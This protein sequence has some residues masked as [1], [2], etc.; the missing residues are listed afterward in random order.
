MDKTVTISSSGQKIP[1]G[2]ILC[3][4]QNYLKHIDEMGSSK[5]QT[6]VI[7]IK[8]ATALV[9]KGGSIQLP[10]FTEN[11]HH[12]VE[13]VVVIGKEGKDIGRE[14]T[15]EFI[16]GYALGLD[17]TLR[18]MQSA[19]KKKGLPWALAKGFDT[20]APISSVILKEE[21]PDPHNLDLQL[22]V[23]GQLRQKGNTKD[24][25]FK[26]DEIISYLS[27][28]FTLER[29]DL[30]FTGTPEG[31]SKIL[32]GDKIKAQLGELIS[33]EFPVV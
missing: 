16:L 25:L 33:I 8:P 23:N 6:P 31:V 29:G 26:L 30:I 27:K 12:E 32:P 5:P 3:L 28:F 4:G 15:D 13:F 9:P 21:V 1:V 10:A 19:A 2:K 7:F 22:W 20:S 24:M 14:K 11:V 18:D 17:I